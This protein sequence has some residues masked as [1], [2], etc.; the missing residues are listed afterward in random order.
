MYIYIY[1]YKFFFFLHTARPH[2]CVVQAEVSYLRDFQSLRCFLVRP[3]QKAI[4]DLLW[5][6]AAVLLGS[7]M[8][9]PA[10]FR[11]PL[12]LFLVPED[13]KSS[14]HLSRHHH[15]ELIRQEATESLKLP[16][17]ACG[18]TLGTTQGFR[19][20]HNFKLLSCL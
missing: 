12:H 13:H 3:L 20:F 6:T 10:V 5:E 8:L 9:G 19:N 1:I 11:R 4:A 15:R 2:F 14:Q 7:A 18:V 16:A 17:A